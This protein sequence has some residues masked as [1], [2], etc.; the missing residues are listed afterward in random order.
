MNSL[1]S[2][3]LHL[4]GGEQQCPRGRFALTILAAYGTY[5]LLLPWA[6]HCFIALNPQSLTAELSLPAS[7]F[8]L[9]GAAAGILLTLVSLLLAFLPLS[10]LALLG[11]EDHLS[12]GYA[13]LQGGALPSA[14]ALSDTLWLC[15]LGFLLSSGVLL[16]AGSVA[17]GAAW[18]R[19]KDA[20]RSPLFL[21]LG[22]T[23]VLGFDNSGSYAA[24][25]SGIYLLGPL[26]LIILYSQPSRRHRGFTLFRTPPAQQ[27]QAA[28]ESRRSGER[29]APSAQQNTPPAANGQRAQKRDQKN[30]GRLTSSPPS[31]ERSPHGA[32]TRPSPSND[33]GSYRR[34]MR[35]RVQQARRRS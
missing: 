10:P 17:F 35:E 30:R 31:Q 29:E 12:K 4:T 11:F 8:A 13:L 16:L 1:L 3:W 34:K 20:G 2:S 5:H 32:G 7:L 14:A 26:W 22:L 25:A 15:W 23:Y 24:E 27:S 33:A 21:L 18:R 6:L 9:L 28:G 19:L